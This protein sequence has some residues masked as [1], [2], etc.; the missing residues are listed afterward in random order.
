MFCSDSGGFEF[1]PNA[2]FGRGVVCVAAD[3]REVFH[4]FEHIDGFGQYNPA[5]ANLPRVSV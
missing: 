2:D 1:A 4:G 3:D 5:V